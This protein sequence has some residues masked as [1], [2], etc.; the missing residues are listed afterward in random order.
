[1][2][3]EKR[4][5]T[6]NKE[7]EEIKKDAFSFGGME[8]EEEYPPKVKAMF[9]AVLELFSSGRELNTLKVSE[10]TEKAG[11]GKG[12]A[13]EYFSTKEEIIVSAMEY[14]AK[15]HFSVIIDL[16]ERGQSFQEIL[17]RG[18]DM[19]EAVNEKYHGFAVMEKIMRDSTITGSGILEVMEKRRENCN[20]GFLVTER[21][22]K[23]A[24]DSGVI[25]ESDPCKVWSAI[26]SQLIVY[27][28]YLTHRKVF[29]H[30]EREEA[31]EF[32]Y[33]NILKILN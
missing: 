8:P 13:Y 30:M 32:V 19:M 16:I 18:M 25:K 21:L 7:T 15:R 5:N 14:E 6:I 9:E 1:M 11:I 4:K 24:A 29:G 28:C 10:I 22:M 3:G 2:E 23:L 17:F 12:T 26:L 27:A 31:R 33:R 20:I